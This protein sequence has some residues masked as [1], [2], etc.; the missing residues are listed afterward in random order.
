MVINNYVT[1][2]PCK[3]L[4]ALSY[5]EDSD[6]DD[7]PELGERNHEDSNN[8]DDEEEEE[9]P[10]CAYLFLEIKHYCPRMLL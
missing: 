8:S 6:D 10:A 3:V 7:M 5:D 1:Q 4:Q 2:E 9:A